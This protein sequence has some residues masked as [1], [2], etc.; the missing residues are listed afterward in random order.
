MYKYITARYVEV[1][2]VCD[3]LR[4]NHEYR[5]KNATCY[6]YVTVH[7]VYACNNGAGFVY[8]EIYLVNCLRKE[9]DGEGRKD[10]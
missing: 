5:K 4:S 10:T 1:A 7:E 3:S 6:N 8:L 2:A 9:E